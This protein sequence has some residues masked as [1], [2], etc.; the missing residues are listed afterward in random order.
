MIPSSSDDEATPS[1]VALALIRRALITESATDVQ[2]TVGR[3]LMGVNPDGR[4]QIIT[5]LALIGAFLARRVPAAELDELFTELDELDVMQPVERD[6]L[7]VFVDEM[8]RLSGG[9]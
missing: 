7:K 4:R 1:A 8:R 9:S 5:H 2:A 6:A 3:A